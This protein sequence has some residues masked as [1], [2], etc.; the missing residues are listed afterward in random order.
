MGRPKKTR[1]GE[2]PPVIRRIAIQGSAEWTEWL[3]R[4]A[5]FC[6]TDTSKL[7]D[8]AVARYLKEQG[9]P[10]PAPDRVP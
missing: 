4:G 1:K 2:S 8:I 9:F 3:D 5:K 10:D 7:I 6:R